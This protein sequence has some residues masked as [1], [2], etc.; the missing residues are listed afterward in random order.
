[1][2]HLIVLPGNSSKNKAWG[3]LILEHYTP[4]FDSLFML[5]YDHWASGEANINFA[6]EEVKLKTHIESLSS[7]TEIILFAKSA[8]S[9]LALQAI[10]H[11]VLKP[12]QVVFFGMPLDLAADKHFK[13]SWEL[14]SSLNVPT[15]AF[16]NV[17]DPTTS[18]EFTRS[19][20]AT[21]NRNIEL[22]ATVGIDH[23]YG[24]LNTYDD[25]IKL[26]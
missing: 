2:R 26:K 7:D 6:I 3:E 21:H 4:Q 8:G 9:L 13:D 20:L 17:A 22:I 23:W 24:D 10:H 25:F 1:M 15:I 18:Y 5:E 19:M 12:V 14:L 16:H 11:G